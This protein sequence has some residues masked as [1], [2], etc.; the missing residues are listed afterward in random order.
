M[1][2]S[3]NGTLWGWGLNSQGQ[4]GDGTVT[5]RSS[6]VQIGTLNNWSSVD[7]NQNHSIAVKNDGT[8]WSWGE[9]SSGRL[10]LNVGSTTRSSPVQVGT[11]GNWSKIVTGTAHN[12]SIK[13]DGTLWSWGSNSIGQLGDGTSI[14]R[15]SPVQI[16]TRNDWNLIG[17][18]ITHSL[19]IRNDGTLWA[20][21]QHSYGQLGLN[22]VVDFSTTRSSPVQVGTRNDWYRVAAGS[23]HSLAIRTDGTL[24]SWGRN[25]YGQLG[26]GTTLTRSSPVQVGTRNDWS[27]VFVSKDTSSAIYGTSLAIKTDGTMWGWGLNTENQGGGVPLNTNRSSPVQVGN[28]KTWVSA[29]IGINHSIAL[30]NDGALASWGT[31]NNGIMGRIAQ[32]PTINRSSPVQVG[33]FDYSWLNSIISPGDNV[34][35][36]IKSDGTLWTWGTSTGTGQQAQGINIAL[37][38]PT[39]VG[40]LNNWKDVS[41]G[42]SHTMVLKEYT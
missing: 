20:W 23:V 15:S 40:T 41:T 16:G 7:C 17:A 11:L 5:N 25:Q 33:D 35:T 28:L 19:A 34:T 12:L 4:I 39:Q 32:T 21:G 14:T 8:L 13:T 24:W 30:I 26:D 29:S 27:N 1:A 6:P 3:T 9:N 10:G 36:A 42:P 18:G 2:V 22:L 31:G 38:S 37:S